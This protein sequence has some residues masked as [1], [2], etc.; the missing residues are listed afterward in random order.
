MPENI[1]RR[2]EPR[3]RDLAMRALVGRNLAS[4]GQS[5]IATPRRPE[6]LTAR[7]VPPMN[8]FVR[9]ARP[10]RSAR[11]ARLAGLGRRGLQNRW[12]SL[13]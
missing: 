3:N 7:R 13:G 4:R 11:P 5:P 2:L 10:T 1:R 12:G 9:P 8:P 6:I